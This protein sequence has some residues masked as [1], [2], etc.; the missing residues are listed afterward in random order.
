MCQGDC[1]SGSRTIPA[2]EATEF[3]KRH[4]EFKLAQ[5][6]WPFNE[7]ELSK[8]ITHWLGALLRR[9]NILE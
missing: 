4:P 5:P 7:S 1:Q 8:N 3:A 9:S 6:A 2:V